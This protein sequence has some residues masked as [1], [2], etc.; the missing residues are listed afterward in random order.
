VPRSPGGT[1][2]PSAVKSSSRSLASRSSNRIWRP[3]R[4]GSS[5]TEGGSSSVPAIVNVSSPVAPCRWPIR[6]ITFEIVPPST[7]I[8][9]PLGNVVDVDLGGSVELEL[10]VDVDVGRI[11][12]LE[13]DVDEVELVD[14]VVGAAEVVLVV[15]GCDVEVELE[16]ELLELVELVDEEVEELVEEDVDVLE[17]D[18]VELVDEDVELEVEDDVVEEV[19][20]VG[21]A[22]VV[23]VV[24]G[25]DVDVELEVEELVEDDVEL[26]D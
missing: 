5:E 14:D 25:C 20:E 13:L 4:S 3:R 11:V 19:D 26:V 16:V 21:V 12:E 8:A 9:S 18:E 24:D 17:V 22:E 6:T 15:D 1:G 7:Q 2:V 23:L 10:D